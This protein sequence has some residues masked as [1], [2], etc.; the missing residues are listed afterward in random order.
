MTSLK[1][2]ESCLVHFVL[3]PCTS[4]PVFIPFPTFNE[5]REMVSVRVEKKTNEERTQQSMERQG[6]KDGIRN[7]IGEEKTI[8]NHK[9]DTKIS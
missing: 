1:S 3:F 9:F 8:L 2:K 7:T 4:T 6:C 5:G